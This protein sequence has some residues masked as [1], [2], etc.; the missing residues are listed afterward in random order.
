MEETFPT[1]GTGRTDKFMTERVLDKH[2]VLDGAVIEQLATRLELLL[3]L[4]FNMHSAGTFKVALD[5]LLED[6][7][8]I[9]L[10][11]AATLF[12][13]DEQSG[14]LLPF[15]GTFNESDPA[16]Q[17]RLGAARDSMDAGEV[18]AF[19]GKEI[20]RGQ[21]RFRRAYGVQPAF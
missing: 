14:D 19:S 8:S 20:G 11:A 10:G 17:A 13:R 6:S 15:S 7:P 9:F 1:T 18:L 2:E 3:E 5:L 16:S 12:I 4:L 21:N